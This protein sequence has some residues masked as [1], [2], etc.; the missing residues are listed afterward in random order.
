[1]T[2][3]T[4]EVMINAAVALMAEANLEQMAVATE[5]ENNMETTMATAK[6]E[7]AKEQELAALR[8]RLAELTA[9]EPKAA[10]KPKKN[11]VP[12]KPTDKKYVLLTKKF[13]NWGTVPQQQLDLSTILI[14]GMEIGVEYTE[15]DIFNMLI[16]GCGDFPSLCKSKQDVTYLFRY[17]RGLKNDGKYAGLIGRNLI[18]MY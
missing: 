11:Q 14:R 12:G 4:Q 13:E 1:M 16:D 9:A 5:K 7:T 15:K 10:D 6:L 17:Y 18:R 3:M 8:A 2:T